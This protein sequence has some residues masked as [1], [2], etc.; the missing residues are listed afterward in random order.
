[1]RRAVAGSPPGLASLRAIAADTVRFAV[2][3]PVLS[4]LLFTPAVPG[5]EPSERAYRPSLEV[6]ALIVTAVETAVT[7]GELHAAAATEHGLALFITV[8]AGIGAMQ[9]GNDQHADATSGKYVPLL[10]P[11]L[12]MFAEYFSPDKPPEWA[13]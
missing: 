3:H 8:S 5:F 2:D 9:W 7:V 12:D 10:G 6:R 11:A 4:Q 13:P 1:V